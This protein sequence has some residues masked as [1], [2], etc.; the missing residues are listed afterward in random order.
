M[1]EKSHFLEQ[2]KLFIISFPFSAAW[3]AVRR[4]FLLRKSA[5]FKKAWVGILLP[6][7]LWIGGSYVP[8]SPVF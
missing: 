7:S 2:R 4:F 5:Q 8:L 1:K 6:L 3:N